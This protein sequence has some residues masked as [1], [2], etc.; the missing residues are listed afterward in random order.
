MARTPDG[1]RM[2]TVLDEILFS[3]GTLPTD[4]IIF[5]LG[6][7]DSELTPEKRDMI[8]ELCGLLREMQQSTPPM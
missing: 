1:Q 2:T 8:T 5:K 7:D 3:V 4:V 6:L